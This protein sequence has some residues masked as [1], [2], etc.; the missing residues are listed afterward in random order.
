[1]ARLSPVHGAHH[2]VL[3]DLQ[4]RTVAAKVVSLLEALRN[5]LL[6]LTTVQFTAW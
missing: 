5:D 3:N 6:P 2:E 1:M 4:H